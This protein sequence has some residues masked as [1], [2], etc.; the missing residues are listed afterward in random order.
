[1]VFC[2]IGF[3][4]KQVR[5]FTLSQFIL[6]DTAGNKFN[7]DSLKGKV[8]F[9]DCW[10]PGCVPCRNEMPYSQ[11]LQQRLHAMNM[12]SNIVFVTISFKQTKYEWLQALHELQ[13]PK[14]INLYAPGG[15]Y[16]ATFIKDYFPTYRVFS[17]QGVLDNAR[18]TR[19]SNF[20]LTDFVLFAATKGMGIDEALK[21]F[22]FPKHDKVDKLKNSV[23]KEFFEI[24]IAHDKDFYKD[25]MA[26][27]KKMH[28]L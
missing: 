5:T 12:D 14:A 24:E 3:A 20:I 28:E 18:C 26:L 21:V 25:F 15:I 10:F 1:M 19:A 2:T 11:L 6:E 22:E 23:L 9:V 13:M 8:V 17:S 27:R 7:L 4:Q 16:E